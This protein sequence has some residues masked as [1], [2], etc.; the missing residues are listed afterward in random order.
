MAAR[1]GEIL[2]RKGR[3]VTTIAPDRTLHDV[4]SLLEQ[5]G[6][7]ALVVSRDGDDVAG[8]I[9]ERDVVR[10]L[11]RS[12]AAALDQTVESVMTRDVAT[13]DRSATADEIMARMTQSRF[14][15]VPVLVDGRLAGIISIGDVVKSRMDELEVRAE[16]L[17]TYVTGTSY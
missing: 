4:L 3:D 7:G 14:R 2:D 16:N 15:H 5:R 1:I 6:I 13:C 10:V 11:A 9:S 8:V 12:G 17:E